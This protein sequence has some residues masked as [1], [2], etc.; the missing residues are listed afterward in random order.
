VAIPI[1][2][3]IHGAA[4]S[5]VELTPVR[6]TPLR[7]PTSLRLLLASAPPFV[8]DVDNGTVRSIAGIRAASR[9]DVIVKGVAGA[10]GIIIVS[11]G[12]ISTLYG[13][14]GRGDRVFSLGNGTS[15]AA[16]DDTA[17]VWVVTKAA[18]PSRCTLRAV[19]LAGRQLQPPTS[20][21]CVLRIDPGG[22]S[23]VVADGRFLIDTKSARTILK[24]RALIVAAT[25]KTLILSADSKITLLNTD[26]RQTHQ[27]PW[28]SILFGL[29]ESVAAPHGRY[30]A[31][32]FGDPAWN[33]GPQQALDVWVLDT[34]TAQL[35]HMPNMPALVSLKRTSITWTADGRLVLVAYSG[36]N[37]VLA[38]WKPGDDQ[39]ATKVLHLPPRSRSSPSFAVLG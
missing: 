37:D 38:L 12:L 26:T 33:G 17:A 36:G 19:G 15:V 22:T 21:P 23:R 35:T 16:A 4:A 20:F 8:F 11:R 6:G 13:V 29:G 18:K 5:H 2:I 14:P 3:A 1:G 7:E 32:K 30:I 10:G 28:P 39:L 27:I 34:R 25:G 9:D 31:L 24:T